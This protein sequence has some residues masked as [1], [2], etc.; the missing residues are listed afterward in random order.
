M[1]CT[2]VESGL[3]VASVRAL[4]SGS[5]STWDMPVKPNP[6]DPLPGLRELYRVVVR[7]DYELGNANA[8]GDDKQFCRVVPEENA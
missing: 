6:A 1:F 8:G 7:R 2:Q 3:T 5:T 4:S